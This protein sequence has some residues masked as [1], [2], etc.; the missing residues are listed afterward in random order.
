MATSH[1]L[2][3]LDTI[4]VDRMQEKQQHFKREKEI[5]G[6]FIASFVL[7]ILELIKEIFTRYFSRDPQSG[8][9]YFFLLLS[10]RRPHRLVSFQNKRDSSTLL[11]ASNTKLTFL[12]FKNININIYFF[13]LQ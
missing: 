2:I 3:Y 10:R 11:G 5:S 4:F 1:M 12:S 6:L 9:V 13:R 7:E 8:Y